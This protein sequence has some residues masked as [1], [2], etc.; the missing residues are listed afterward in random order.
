MLQTKI[1]Q[2]TE[3]ILSKYGLDFE[4]KKLPLTAV[5]KITSIDQEGELITEFK[6]YDSNYFGLVNSKT[7]NVIHTVSKSYNVSQN[8]DV[9]EG[10]LKGVE[11][12][13][14]K[15]RVSKA[16]SLNGGRKTFVQFEVEGEST[17]GDD[18]LKKYI[19]AIDSNDGSTGLTFG[20]GDLTMSCHNQYH[21]F[22]RKNDIRLLHNAS[23]AEKMQRIPIIIE[24]SL[25]AL[26]KQ[27][28]MYQSFQSTTASLDLVS[29]LARQ[30]AEITPEDMKNFHD[31]SSRKRNM[32]WD[33]ESTI[34]SEMNEKGN[35]LWGLHSGVTK[36]TTHMKSAP[37][38]DNGKIESILMG[39]A[40][41][42]NQQSIEFASN[43]LLTI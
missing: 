16:G 7:G 35:N 19:T 39:S 5:E 18:T 36:Y 42:W 6:D 2:Q 30:L 29:K 1:K 9:V 14:D 25:K 24:E 33:L 41:K 31:I 22:S 37:R 13:G 28:E 10:I 23:L 21:L 4:I 3:E 8:Y 20:I 34:I 38:R 40:Y 17:V 11:S 26:I 27:V 32:Y 43:E 12:F 15:L